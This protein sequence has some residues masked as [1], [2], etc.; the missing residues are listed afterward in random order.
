VV[1][2]VVPISQKLR[3]HHRTET[4]PAS[5]TASERSSLGWFES[6]RAHRRNQ[7]RDCGRGR[8]GLAM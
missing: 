5:G 4:A 8:R 7:A 6:S 2:F 1:P 3:E